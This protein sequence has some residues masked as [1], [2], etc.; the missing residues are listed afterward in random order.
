[1]AFGSKRV[2]AAGD[3]LAVRQPGSSSFSRFTGHAG[4]V[5]AVA[6]SPDGRL[7]ASGGVDK[8]VRVW[9][10]EDASEIVAYTGHTHSVLA[11]A[12]LPD[13]KSLYSTGQDGTLRRWAVP[14]V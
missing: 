11:V 7:L 9:S 2:A 8:L 1:L 5:L 3:Y 4:N 14:A 6:F 12:F 10:T 13:G